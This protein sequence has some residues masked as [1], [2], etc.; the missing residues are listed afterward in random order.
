MSLIDLAKILGRSADG[1]RVGLYNETEFS[2]KLRPTVLRIGRRI[3]FRTAQLSVA[4]ELD[5]PPESATHD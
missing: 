5:Q 1:I 2:K 3:Y 4:L